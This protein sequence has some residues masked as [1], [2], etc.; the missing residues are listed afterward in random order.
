MARD[1]SD[2]D[3]R[4]GDGRVSEGKGEGETYD[5]DVHFVRGRVGEEGLGD[6]ED[7]VLGRGREGRPPPAVPPGRGGGDAGHR[8]AGASQRWREAGGRARRRRSPELASACVAA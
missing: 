1:R 3:K 2:G 7:G 4:R 6:A 8:H 5:A